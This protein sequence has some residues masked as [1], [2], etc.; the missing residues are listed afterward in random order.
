MVATNPYTVRTC[1]LPNGDRLPILCL[2]GLPVA[3][4][5]DWVLGSLWPEGNASNTMAAKLRAV[6]HWLRYCDSQCLD[7]E[8][9]VTSGLF[10]SQDEIGRV[11][12]WLRVPIGTPV[13][14]KTGKLAVDEGTQAA[15][16]TFIGGYLR[17]LADRAIPGIQ[18]TTHDHVEREYLTWRERWL[19]RTPDPGQPRDRGERFGLTPDQQDLFLQAIHPKGE[20]NPFRTPG[21]RARNYALL[22]MLFD[23]GLRM[24]EPLMLR[25][26]DLFFKDHQ[27]R[28][29]G[30]RNDPED[31]RKII[32]SP[33]K[34]KNKQQGS[35]RRLK[36]TPRCQRALET[37]MNEDRR[38]EAIF[39]GA[40]KSPYVFTSELGRPL[41]TRRL[42][43]IFEE[44]RG[45]L[46]ELGETFTPHVLRHTFVEEYIRSH[47][48]F[49][50]RERQ[51]LCILL[52]WSLTSKMPDRYGMPAIV[53]SGG[54]R[55]AALSERRHKRAL[56]LI[57]GEDA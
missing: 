42:E 25:T 35:G 22:L 7:W 15:R 6:G 30:R 54:E 31:P 9:R 34:G 46:P 55:S 19:A 57:E 28:I 10:L 36:F 2:D 45:E 8:L 38:N 56:K 4:T 11:M 24:A 39:P 32:P 13:G 50:I 18:G 14:V 23:H 1:T 48:N 47:P 52:D 12:K 29:P 27:F 37:W 16:M 20:R 21:M 3:D 5:T 33:K 43:A 26:G 40:R 51:D 49:T 17:W 41:S 53:E 44:V